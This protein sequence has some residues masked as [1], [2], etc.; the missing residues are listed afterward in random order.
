MAKYQEELTVG[1][2]QT[3]LNWEAA[4]TDSPRMNDVEQEITWIDIQNA[5]HTLKSH[6]EQ[7]E[8][9]I[10]PELSV[11]FGYINGISALCRRIGSIIIFGHDYLVDYDAR[12]VKNQA[13]VMVPQYWPDKSKRG[14]SVAEHT[15]GKT[16]PSPGEKRRLKE[17]G[18]KFDADP[19]IY[20]FDGG[21]FGRIGV[22]ICYDFMDVERFVLYRNNIHHLFVLAYNRDIRSFYHIAEAMSRTVFC[23]V[24]VCNTGY[25][26][27]SVVVSPYYKPF[28]RTIY[29]HEG[30]EMLSMQVVKLPVKALDVAQRGKVETDSSGDPVFKERP[31]GFGIRNIRGLRL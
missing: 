18:W 19:I 31:P 21:E 8:I 9:V 30:R 15:L 1:L 14:G 12:K 11:P 20:V 4:W 27:G 5:F 16:Y 2:I 10:L 26:G 28:K 24:I 22:C 7:P 25:Y 3:N 6:E 29:R 17:V 13:K 23:N